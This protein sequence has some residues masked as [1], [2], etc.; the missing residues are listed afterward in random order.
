MSKL[1]H[2]QERMEKHEQALIALGYWELRDFYLTN[3]T[4]KKAAKELRALSGELPKDAELGYTDAPETKKLTI[5]AR[6]I[7]MPKWAEMVR[8]VDVPESGQ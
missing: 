6:R 8:Q 4:S 7:D 2:P 5:R 3:I 1:N